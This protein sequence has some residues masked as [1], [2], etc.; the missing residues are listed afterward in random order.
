MTYTFAYDGVSGMLNK[1]EVPDEDMVLFE[2]TYQQDANLLGVL[3]DPFSEM[4]GTCTSSDK[5]NN[6]SLDLNYLGIVVS[7]DFDVINFAL[8]CGWVPNTP[9]LV[10]SLTVIGGDEEDDDEE[11]AAFRGTKAGEQVIEVMPEYDGKKVTTLNLKV[12][13]IAWKKFVL[14]Y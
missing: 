10:K 5:L 7:E 14:S 1:I 3:M 2:A 11:E 6:F 8:W 13:D 4:R 12:G 9:N